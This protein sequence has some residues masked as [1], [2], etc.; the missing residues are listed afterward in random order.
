MIVDTDGYGIVYNRKANRIVV[1]LPQT[2]ETLVGTT[3]PF[4]NR[5]V[6]IE[7]RDM[8]LILAT[9]RMVFER[10]EQED[11]VN[12]EVKDDERNT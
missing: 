12:D 11:E 9:A 2:V 6:D 1:T 4:R 3:V 10:E 7:D 8:M 5:K